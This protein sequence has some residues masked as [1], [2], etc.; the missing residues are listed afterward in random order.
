MTIQ[1][2]SNVDINSGIKLLYTN[3]KPEPFSLENKQI[4]DLNNTIIPNEYN[5][6]LANLYLNYNVQF[7]NISKQRLKII[8]SIINTGYFIKTKLNEKDYFLF[9]KKLIN[10]LDFPYM[11]IDNIYYNSEHKEVLPELQLIKPMY[12]LN[13]N[14]YYKKLKTRY[15]EPIDLKK[16]LNQHKDV[17][18]LNNIHVLDVSDVFCGIRFCSNK[19]EKD[20][21]NLYIDLLKGEFD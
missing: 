11:F 18:E 9:L 2:P 4:V 5:V 7:E 14:L 3:L 1:F 17:W 21:I 20:L 6:D 16:G 8:L 10:E 13:N 15:V 19:F 12:F